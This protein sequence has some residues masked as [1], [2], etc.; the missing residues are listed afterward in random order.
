MQGMVVLCVYIYIYGLDT[1]LLRV[2]RFLGSHTNSVFLVRS[3]SRRYCYITDEGR[4]GSK[5]CEFVCCMLCVCVRVNDE[6]VSLFYTA[7]EATPSKR[8]N[9]GERGGSSGRGRACCPGH[10]YRW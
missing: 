1:R 3:A 5:T 10:I 6:Q 7:R 4:L 9:Q 2:S 8:A